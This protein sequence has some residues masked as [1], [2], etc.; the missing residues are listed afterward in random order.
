MC[1]NYNNLIL[2]DFTGQKFTETE[3]WTSAGDYQVCTHLPATFD[4]VK[5]LNYMKKKHDGQV[6]AM[7]LLPGHENVATCCRSPCTHP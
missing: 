6:F 1:I 3:L 5:D 2:S 4:V 7:W